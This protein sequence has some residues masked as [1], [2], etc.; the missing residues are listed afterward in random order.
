MLMM[1]ARNGNP[2]TLR[3]LKEIPPQDVHR[4]HNP[5]MVAENPERVALSEGG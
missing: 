1:D 2:G 4:Q 3:P 5:K